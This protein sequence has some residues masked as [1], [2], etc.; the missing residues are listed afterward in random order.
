VGALGPFKVTDDKGRAVLSGTVHVAEGWHPDAAAA[1]GVLG[2]PATTAFRVIGVRPDDQNDDDG[3]GDGDGDGDGDSDEHEEDTDEHED[4]EKEDDEEGAAAASRRNELNATPVLLELT[5]QTGRKHQLRVHCAQVLKCVMVGDYKHGYR[6]LRRRRFRNAV[7]EW[8]TI[9]KNIERDAVTQEAGSFEGDGVFER[10]RAVR[11]AELERWAVTREMGGKWKHDMPRRHAGAP[12]GDGGGRAS[13]RA[14]VEGNN[15]DGEDVVDKGYAAVEE[16]ARELRGGE[17]GQKS[18]KPWRWD[19]DDADDAVKDVKNGE[20]EYG[21]MHD[22][23][24]DDEDEDADDGDYEDDAVANIVMLRKRR[25][26]RGEKPG[27]KLVG[28]PLHLHARE[29][30]FTAGFGA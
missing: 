29:L 9:I 28:V 27:A 14:N 24:D 25:Q 2:R 3:N 10:E 16:E 1:G 21:V 19:A 11:R 30:R 15:G 26:A 12:D 23:D 4:V 13:Y 20:V 18:S 8:K 17:S 6:D 5:P 22:D 7:P